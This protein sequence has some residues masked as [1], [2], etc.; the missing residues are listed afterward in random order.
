[1]LR[2][3]MILILIVYSAGLLFLFIYSLTQSNLIYKYIRQKNR[4]KKKPI[5]EIAISIFP[6][7]TIQLPVYNELYVIERLIDSVCQIDYPKDK[8]EIQILDDS[9]DETQSIILKKIVECKKRGHDIV[10]IHR[11]NRS[12]YKAG[13][14]EAGLEIAKGELLAIF[15]ADFV[16]PKDFLLKTVSQFTNSKV[17]M[18]QTRWD[19]LNRN[20]SLLTKLQAFALDAHFSVEQVGR[21]SGKGFINFNGT[22]GIWRKSC[23]LDAGNWSPDTL[24]ED[25]D[26]SYRAQLK[27][28][29][30]V[31]LENVNS[32]AELPPVMSALKSQQYRWTKGGAETAKKH[33]WNVIKSNKSI[34][35]KWHGI[36][37]LMNSAVF[38]SIAICSILSVPLLSIKVRLPEFKYIFLLASFFILSFAVLGAMYF[39]SCANQ[40][41]NKRS[42]IIP[43]LLTFPLFLSVS[44][45]L[46]LHNAIA[47]IEG[48]LGRK[49]SFVR[50]PKFNLNKEIRNIKSNVYINKKINWLTYI[51]GFLIFYFSFGIFKAFKHQDFGLLP[52]HIMLTLGYSIIFYYSIKQNKILIN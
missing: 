47:V 29:E 35:V 12:G 5:K 34:A 45:G 9:T 38:V 36:M 3:L 42:A 27:G 19:H 40:H 30:F 50:T 16:P 8:L 4:N 49:T 13:A 1:M 28:W 32:P 46:S 43:F 25:L 11:A 26:L 22:A 51:E 37:H 48:Y 39:I 52:F 20:Y 10:Y 18:V 44:M 15:D 23:I 17:G 31:Y 7:V 6:S 2:L 24:T 41:K 14:L 21:N 33:F